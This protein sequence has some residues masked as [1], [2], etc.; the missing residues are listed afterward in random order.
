VAAALNTAWELALDDIQ[1]MPRRFS[2][3]VNSPP[4]REFRE[5][6]LTRF[7]FRIIFELTATEIRVSAF[8]HA[9]RHS[10]RWLDQLDAE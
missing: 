2:P 10:R 7:G 6:Y 5:C 4:G 8:V 1:A 9:R 3:V